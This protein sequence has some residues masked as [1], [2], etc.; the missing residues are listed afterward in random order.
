MN[1]RNKVL[2]LHVKEPIED[3]VIRS[4]IDNG[5]SL[6]MLLLVVASRFNVDPTDGETVSLV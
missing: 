4:A 3:E 1:L 5:L 6:L 2:H